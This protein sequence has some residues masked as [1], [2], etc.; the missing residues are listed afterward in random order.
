MTKKGSKYLVNS[1]EFRR[2]AQS[3]TKDIENNKTPKRKKEYTLDNLFSVERTFIKEINTIEAGKEA[4]SK[5]IDYITGELG[6]IL[7]AKPFFRERETVFNKEIGDI[8]REKDVAKLMTYHPN[9]KLISF[10]M[11]NSKSLPKKIHNIYKRYCTI[12]QN[13]ITN[14]IPLAFNR[15]KIFFKTTPE[16]HLDLLD[17]VNVCVI[18]L[19]DAIDKYVGEY[20]RGVFANVCISRMS[21]SMME[22]YNRTMIKMYPKDKKILYRINTI[23]NRNKIDSVDI[24]AE[25]Y[26]K[27]LKNDEKEGKKPISKPMSGADIARYLNSTLMYSIVN[28]EDDEAPET[29]SSSYLNYNTHFT[30]DTNQIEVENDEEKI[31][32][33]DFIDNIHKEIG[34]TSII[35]KKVIRLKGLM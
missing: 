17:F 30:F 15:A 32:N 34:K 4:Y 31:E 6:N 2:L 12:R 23:K 18:G 11:D 19:A 35:E 33:K 13:I 22:E 29:S 28:K 10:I 7:S 14:N 20:D 1:G 3:V 16:E 8:F 27:S 21:G 9:Y 24:I 25:M 26:N 5:F